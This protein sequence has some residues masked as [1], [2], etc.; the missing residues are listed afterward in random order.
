MKKMK[1]MLLCV[2]LLTLCA[3]LLGACSGGKKV[4]VDPAALAKDLA[5]EAVTSEELTQIADSMVAATYYIPDDTY[6]AGWAYKGSGAT[7][8]EV[9]VIECKKAEQ[10]KD[11]E[12][13]LQDHVDSQSELYAS[14]NPDEV[15]KL[16][17]ALIKSAGTYV[18]LCVCD[19]EDQATSIFKKAGF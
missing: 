8:C 15:K 6:A 2:S 3:V 17:K 9:A 11:V 12:K 4:S 19:N 10:T 16:D 7:A 14:Y 13:L 5:S 18:V 1:N